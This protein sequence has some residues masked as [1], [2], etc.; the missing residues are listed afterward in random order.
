[1]KSNALT[2]VQRHFPNVE[3][4]VDADDSIAVKV[5]KR[6]SDNG[7][8]KDA[9]ECA[10]AKACVRELEADGAI[11]NVSYSYVITGKKATRYSTSVAVAR[12][13]TSFDRHQDF[14]P[15]TYVLSKIK[16]SA[17]LGSD[18]GGGGHHKKDRAP[19]KIPKRV[20]THHT[21]NIRITEKE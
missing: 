13:I 9:G 5:T 3:K 14:Q 20:H 11:I 7:R 19:W 1:M 15:G 21:E 8:K 4:I 17:R 2:I 10:L 12:E 6:D 18:K 16:P